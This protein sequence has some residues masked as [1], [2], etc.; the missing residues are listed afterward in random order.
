MVLYIRLITPIPALTFEQT[1]SI[2]F[3]QLSFSSKSTP[4][5]VIV[6]VRGIGAL[7]INTGLLPTL[8]FKLYCEPI[9]NITLHFFK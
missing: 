4:K 6:P 8:L 9:L 5:Q 1:D 2:S 3:P 7:L